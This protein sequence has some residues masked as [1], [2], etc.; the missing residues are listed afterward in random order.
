M[1]QLIKMFTMLFTFIFTSAALIVLIELAMV[2]SKHIQF[3]QTNTLHMAQ[4]M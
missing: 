2:V 4:N 1:E 3:M